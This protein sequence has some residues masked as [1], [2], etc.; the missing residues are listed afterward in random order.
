MNGRY[1]SKFAATH[2]ENRKVIKDNVCEL[3]E[4]PDGEFMAVIPVGYAIKTSGGP[5]KRPLKMTIKHL[6]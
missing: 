5:K 3:L 6:E 4:E 2:I 1:V